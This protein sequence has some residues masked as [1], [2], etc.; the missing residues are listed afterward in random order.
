MTLDIVF[1]EHRSS[2]SKCMI[3]R[4][5]TNK[6]DHQ[7]WKVALNLYLCQRLFGCDMKI[8]EKSPALA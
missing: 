8:K 7:Q 6:L 3:S 5:V 4:L 2:E 1:E